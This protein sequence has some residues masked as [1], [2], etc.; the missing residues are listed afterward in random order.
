MIS[1]E[2]R[3]KSSFLASEQT[4]QMT[5]IINSGPKLTAFRV[6]CFIIVVPLFLITFTFTPWNATWIPI[7]GRSYS[8]HAP[9]VHKALPAVAQSYLDALQRAL[10]YLKQVIITHLGIR[11]ET[12]IF[13]EFRVAQLCIA[14]LFPTEC[15]AN[16]GSADA[17]LD[18]ELQWSVIPSL[19]PFVHFSV[20]SACTRAGLMAF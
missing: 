6:C 7:M 5:Q 10:C 2:T 17:I 1:L 4:C 13:N 12:A 19:Y 9:R 20:N 18:S 3:W 11:V 14:S 15:S 16:T 8:L